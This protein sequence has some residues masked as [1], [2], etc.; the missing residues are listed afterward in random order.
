MGLQKADESR[1]DSIDVTH[2]FLDLDF[3]QMNAFHI[4]GTCEI[5][6]EVLLDDVNHL[7]LDLLEMD[8]SSVM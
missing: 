7:A 6:F 2:I 8:V 4:S 1:S 3:T 5:S